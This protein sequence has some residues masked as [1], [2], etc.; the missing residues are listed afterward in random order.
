MDEL[1]L[2][3]R[4][5]DV[6][7]VLWEHGSGTV[8]EV[9]EWLDADVAYTTVLAILRK[10]ESKKLLKRVVEGRGHRYSP[11]IAQRTAQRSAMRRIL[12]G[13]FGGSPEALLLRLVDDECI[14]ADDL[15]AMAARIS[16]S[17]PR[18]RGTS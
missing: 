5:L 16:A 6:M 3:S 1:S 14:D 11:R 12:S 2:G 4:E 15:R 18:K 9:H 10:L 8:A 7:A 17:T 13:F